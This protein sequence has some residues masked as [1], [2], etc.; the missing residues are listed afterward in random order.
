MTQSAEDPLVAQA[1]DAKKHVDLA[2]AIEKLSSEE[3]AHFLHKLENAL[4]KRKIQ[5]TGYIIALPTW[6][7]TMVGAL[8]WFGTHTGFVAWVFVV[9]FACVG[10]ILY[11]FGRWAERA[12][13][14]PPKPPPAASPLPKA[15]ATPGPPSATSKTSSAPPR[16]LRA[17][18]KAAAP[19]AAAPT[20]AAPTAAAPKTSSDAPSASRPPSKATASSATVSKAVAAATATTE[21]AATEPEL[22]E[23]AEPEP[24]G[25]PSTLPG[26]TTAPGD[27]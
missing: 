1:F 27:K 3:A 9:P 11:T 5:L 10:L 17:T 12:A 20:A 13:N 21:P 6:L 24:T 2:R 19:S 8:L 4:R 22:T 7:V 15:T 16:A 26:S 14:A 18:S 23:P 25:A